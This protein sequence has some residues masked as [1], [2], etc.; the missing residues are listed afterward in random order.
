[1]FNSRMLWQINIYGQSLNRDDF[2]FR[3]DF[4]FNHIFNRHQR[5]GQARRDNFRTRL[6]SE[7][8][9]CCLP[10]R[11]F[12]ASRRR[13]PDKGRMRS[14]SSS[15]ICAIFG[16]SSSAA[17]IAP[18]TDFAAPFPFDD[19]DR[20]RRANRHGERGQNLVPIGFVGFFDRNHFVHIEN[21]NDAADIENR[22]RK[23]VI[24]GVFR[25]L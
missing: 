12:P 15:L 1:M 24:D 8:S 5:S 6:H 14:S 21:R 10:A 4:F 23:R 9:K 11:R 19:A 18:P 3:V 2:D 13:S 17:A 16:S 7:F 25:R 22:F 20:F